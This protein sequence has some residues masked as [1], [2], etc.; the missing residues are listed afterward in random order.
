MTMPPFQGDWALVTGASSGIGRE[1]ARALAKDGINCALV[2]RRQALL[3]E[4]AGELERDH[5]IRTL[6]IAVD[7]ARDDA[8]D[9]V[10]DALAG[11]GVRP[12]VLVNNAGAGRWGPFAAT[13]LDRYREILRLNMEATVALCHRFMADLASF[14]SSAVINV[15]SPA[16]LQPVPFMAVYAASKAFV[17]SFSQALYEEW[18]EKGIRVETLV[19]GPTASEFD[20]KAGAYPCG[21]PTERADPAETVAA[22]LA[23]LG[24]TAPVVASAK[25]L[26]K[27]RMFAALAP[28]RM[29]LKEVGRM[30][31]P[32][33]QERPQ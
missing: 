4:L 26:L 6:V 15:S 25:G 17:H 10:A 23:A 1:F 14:P 24:G 29:V 8:V 27:Q 2:A 22:A 33:D 19:P 12:R 21:M 9:R 31:R 18:R 11:A 7:L 16:A 30:F 13:D 5:G 32:R 20:E 28:S 3:D